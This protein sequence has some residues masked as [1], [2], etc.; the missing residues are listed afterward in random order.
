[1]NALFNFIA[2]PFGYVMQFCYWLSQGSYI[3]ALLI[4]AFFMEILMLLIFGIKQQK[5]SIKAASLRP[6]EMAIRKKYAGRNDQPTQQ[7]M[8]MEIQEMQKSEG[9]S[10]FSGC[11]QMLIQL[12]VLMALYNIV[13]NPFKFI[14]GLSNETIQALIDKT[15]EI[16]GV[17]ASA[18]SNISIDRTIN[19]INE[20]KTNGIGAYLGIAEFAEKIPTVEDLP[21][22]TVFG[23]DLGGTPSFDNLSWLLAIPVLTFVTYFLSSKLTRKFMYQPSQGA[24]DQQAACSNNMM[25]FT[26]P[27]MSVFFTFVVPGAIGVYWIFRSILG[28]LKQ[29]I[30]SKVMPVPTF[31]EEDYKQAEKEYF[32]KN[33]NKLPKKERDPNKPKVRSLHHID[34][35][36]YENY[37]AQKKAVG[38]PKEEGDVISEEETK[39]KFGIEKAAVKKDDRKNDTK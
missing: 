27:L 13:Y 14:S 26:M 36:D 21:N 9:Y 8:M 5:N 6:K 17:E 38:T 1:M 11:L 12:P 4:F 39:G 30:L 3:L 15:A 2:I 33:G 24:T 29:F 22:M 34:D 31:T 7:K 23:I 20:I 25:D 19:L 28:T 18:L 32:H 10:P 35:E 16:K 37:D